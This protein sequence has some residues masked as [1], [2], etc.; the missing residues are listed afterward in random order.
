MNATLTLRGCLGKLAR[1]EKLIN[2]LR[3]Q[4]FEFLKE[5]DFKS[6]IVRNPETGRQQLVASKVQAP[7]KP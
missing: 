1:A 6:E 3:R 4:N 5:G 7:R 2:E